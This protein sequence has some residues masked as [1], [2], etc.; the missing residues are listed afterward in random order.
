M[1]GPLNQ[2]ITIWLDKH[3]ISRPLNP[4]GELLQIVNNAQISTL[5]IKHSHEYF[6]NKN[7]S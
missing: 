1:G 6:Q 2:L 4:G 3:N 5:L 7:N